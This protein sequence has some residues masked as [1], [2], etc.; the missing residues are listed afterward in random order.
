LKLREKRKQKD[1]EKNYNKRKE[2]LLLPNGKEKKCQSQVKLLNIILDEQL[3]FRK[4][5][6]SA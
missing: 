6:Q 5:R 2:Y 1:L 4:H 3:P